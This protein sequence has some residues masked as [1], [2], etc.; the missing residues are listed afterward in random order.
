MRVP[1]ADPLLAD[2]EC[3]P[4]I[5]QLPAA[6]G[7]G[8]AN[9]LPTNT[10]STAQLPLHTYK[11]IG[12]TIWMTQTRSPLST[13]RNLPPSHST[14]LAPRCAQA[15]SYHRSNK[16]RTAYTASH[17][18]IQVRI[19]HFHPKNPMGTQKPHQGLAAALNVLLSHAARSRFRQ[20]FSAA[21]RRLSDAAGDGA[22]Y[23]ASCPN[24][25][26]CLGCTAWAEISGAHL[27][28]CLGVTHIRSLMSTTCAGNH[29]LYALCRIL[30]NTL[31]GTK[32]KQGRLPDART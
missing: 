18:L 30:G 7:R 11:S 14:L 17:T 10:Y 24:P 1:R 26:G 2:L 16:R 22:H 13:S 5:L 12:M 27:P 3:A 8:W 21:R 25:T 6:C 23:V 4:P 9:P 15:P 19:V 28:I 32:F 20:H 29:V 31:S